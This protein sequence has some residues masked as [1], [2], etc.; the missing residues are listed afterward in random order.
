M[1]FP[2]PLSKCLQTR[3]ANSKNSK[4]ENSGGV[5]VRANL[6]LPV[7]GRTNVL[8]LLLIAL[9][10]IVDLVRMLSFPK[11][12]IEWDIVYQL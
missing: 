8:L 5:P 2:S 4:C 10:H 1:I 7:E 12:I 11:L 9:R 3:I 6:Q